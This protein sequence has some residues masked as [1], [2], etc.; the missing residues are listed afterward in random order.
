MLKNASGLAMSAADAQTLARSLNDAAV[1]AG[2]AVVTDASRQQVWS[3]LGSNAQ[4]VL[5]ALCAA[6]AAPAISKLPSEPAA[7]R[8]RS[9]CGIERFPEDVLGAIIAFVDLPMRFTCVAACSTLRDA[10]ARLSPRLEHSLV[11]KRFPLI[12]TFGSAGALEQHEQF[13][14]AIDAQL[15]ESDTAAALT[16]LPNCFAPAP[17]DLFR[18]FRGFEAGNAFAVRPET[19]IALEAYTLS[20]EIKAKKIERAAP[21]DDWR[22]IGTLESIYVGTGELQS[23]AAP[24]VVYK[25]TILEAAHERAWRL[26]QNEAHWWFF[27]TVVASRRD[28]SGRLQ[29]AKLVHEHCHLDENDQFAFD[30]GEI[31]PVAGNQALNFYKWKADNVDMYT[32]PHLEL[33]NMGPSASGAATVEATFRWQ[34]GPMPL[35]DDFMTERDA[36]CCLEHYAAWSE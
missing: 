11:A 27:A 30:A 33:E 14:Q 21:G 8:P 16:A 3:L 25:F 4:E 5:R 32:D 18:T 35:D 6:G 24:R 1:A 20:L 28:A 10:C 31:P 22:F 12:N 7:T 15:G 29:F 9:S 36:R 13:V 34:L 17:R 19:S 23:E 26:D 2:N